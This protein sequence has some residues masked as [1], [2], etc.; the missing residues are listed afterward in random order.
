M[1]N[2]KSTDKLIA[3][4]DRLLE[5]LSKKHNLTKKEIIRKSLAK[6]AF[7]IEDKE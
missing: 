1:D 7:V 3:E 6:Y 4:F 2:K 5:E